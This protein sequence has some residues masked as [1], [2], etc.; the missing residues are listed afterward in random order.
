[1]PVCQV[2]VP[3]IR[4][5]DSYSHLSL[6]FPGESAHNALDLLILS[7]M[8]RAAPSCRSLVTLIRDSTSWLSFV[9][10]IRARFTG[11]TAPSDS[12]WAVPVPSR[13]MEKLRAGPSR[14][15]CWACLAPHLAA[16]AHSR[17]AC[18]CVCVCVCLCV[19][20]RV[21]VCVCVLD[22]VCVFVCLCAC[23]CVYMCVCVCVFVCVCQYIYKTFPHR[24]SSSADRA[25][26]MCVWGEGGNI[27]VSAG[28]AMC[29]TLLRD[30]HSRFLYSCAWLSFVTLIRASHSCPSRLSLVT[31][32]SWFA[33]MNPIRGSRSRLTILTW[34]VTT[35]GTWQHI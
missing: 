35:D 33:Y 19:C 21:C 24:C 16:I 34:Y 15:I 9:T 30:F 8:W 28:R 5:S 1:M 7:Y 13:Q 22:C 12:P 23:V 2:T 17:T 32:H 26:R 18:V 4:D 6:S 3:L 31:S 25:I 20:V 10:L 14:C 29:V 27:H 11:R